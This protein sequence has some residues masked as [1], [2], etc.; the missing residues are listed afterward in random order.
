MLHRSCEQQAT[1]VKCVADTIKPWAKEYLYPH[2]PVVTSIKENNLCIVAS[3][4]T[5]LVLPFHKAQTG[6]P[7]R[8]AKPPKVWCLHVF[9]V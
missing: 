8:W 1:S 4:G 5:D 9:N 2:A 7:R 3:E 6:R